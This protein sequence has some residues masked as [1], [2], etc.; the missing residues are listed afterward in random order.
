MQTTEIKYELDLHGQTK[1]KAIPNLVSFL[2]QI[3]HCKNN[4]QNGEIEHKPIMVGI[5]TGSGSHSSHGPVLRNAVENVL[6]RRQ[7]TY[8]LVC[9]RGAF[10][11][12]AMSGV[13]LFEKPVRDTKVV[14]KNNEEFALLQ[15]KGH[16]WQRYL[17]QMKKKSTS[18]SGELSDQFDMGQVNPS[19]AEIA[20]DENNIAKAKEISLKEAALIQSVKAK[21]D[22]E[23]KASLADSNELQNQEVEEMNAIMEEAIQLSKMSAEEEQHLMDEELKQVLELSKNEIYHHDSKQK[24]EEDSINYAIQLSQK[25]TQHHHILDDE[26]SLQEALEKSKSELHFVSI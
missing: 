24:L 18:S 22:N 26:E 10:H 7:M 13:E 1:D 2:D 19:P 12:D 6:K 3:R 23:L 21:E 15:G 16:N 25:E 5:I 11:V 14:V 8:Q 17:L 9:K 20:L 4:A